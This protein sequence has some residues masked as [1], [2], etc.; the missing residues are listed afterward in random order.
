M[1]TSIPGFHVQSGTLLSPLVEKKPQSKKAS[2]DKKYEKNMRCTNCKRMHER[3]QTEEGQVDCRV[4]VRNG[5]ECVRRKRGARYSIRATVPVKPVRRASQARVDIGSSLGR[6]STVTVDSEN[7]LQLN[8]SSSTPGR[9]F[10]C[11]KLLRS[12]IH[13]S[14]STD[15]QTGSAL[16]D[17]PIMLTCPNSVLDDLLSFYCRETFKIPLQ[18]LDCRDVTVEFT[19]EHNQLHYETEGGAWRPGRVPESEAPSVR[20]QRSVWVDQQQDAI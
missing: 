8:V 7:I 11:I 19:C 14:P 2:A 4:C 16:L 9:A 18:L 10:Q 13:I 17:R 20:M 15:M 6:Q 3:C 12:K 1:S 5:I